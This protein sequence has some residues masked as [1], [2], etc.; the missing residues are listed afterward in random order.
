MIM[1]QKT[2]KEAVLMGNEAIALGIIENGCNMA[3]SYPGD[4]GI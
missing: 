3:S 4:S 1:L 2:K